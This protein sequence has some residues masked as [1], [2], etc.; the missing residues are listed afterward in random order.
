[1]VRI[2]LRGKC[3]NIEF[4]PDNG[5]PGRCMVRVE[6]DYDDSP[7]YNLH[8]IQLYVPTKFGSLIEVGLPVTV[9]LEQDW[10]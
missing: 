8:E 10:S 2:N 1:V 6:L 9:T 3:K 5:A 4:T 7:S